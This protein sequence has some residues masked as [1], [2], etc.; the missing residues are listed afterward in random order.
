MSMTSLV[1]LPFKWAWLFTAFFIQGIGRLF[2]IFLGL[3]LMLVGMLL[4]LT[5]VGSVFGVP[6]LIFGFVLLVRGMF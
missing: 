4:I 1:L 6:I 5:I 3:A 2:T